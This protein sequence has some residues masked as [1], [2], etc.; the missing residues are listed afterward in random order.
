VRYGRIT[1]GIKAIDQA[2]EVR[3]DLGRHEVLVQSGAAAG[4][5]E[6]A[7]REA[8]YT[9][10]ATTRSAAAAA[11]AAVRSGCCCGSGAGRGA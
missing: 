9:P 5:I 10:V 11:S 6:A 2:A 1:A 7:I 8:G 3:V 4:A